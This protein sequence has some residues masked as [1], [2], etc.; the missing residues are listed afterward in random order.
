MTK[1]GFFRFSRTGTDILLQ[2]AV[3]GW[4][5]RGCWD[6]LHVRGSISMV[7]LMAQYLPFQVT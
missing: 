2:I 3:F 1:I 5:L 6:T 4:Y 7:D